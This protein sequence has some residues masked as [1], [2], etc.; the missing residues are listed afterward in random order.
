MKIAL[1]P[2][3]AKPYHAGHDGLVRIAASENDLVKLFVSTS[4]RKRPGEIP[5]LGADMLRIWT[6][7]LEPSLPGNV[8]VEYVNVPV[9]GVYSALENAESKKSKDEFFIYSDSEDILK[10][11]EANLKKSAPRL[12]NAKKINLKGVDRTQTVPVSGTKMRQLLSTGNVKKFISLLPP[13]V[14]QHGQEI[15]D[16]LSKNAVGESL[17]RRYVRDIIRG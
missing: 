9:S 6:E 2:M 7:Y 17:I 15:Y 14:Q 13:A 8:E 16:I 10:Y 1:V 3:A 11:R 12:F 4:D 5:I